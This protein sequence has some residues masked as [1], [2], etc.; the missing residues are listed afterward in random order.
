MADPTHAK[1][2]LTWIAQV[3]AIQGRELSMD[4]TRNTV[5]EWDSLGDL[6]L[7][8]TLEED[9]SI[10][11]SADDIAAITSVAEIVALIEKKN[12]LPPG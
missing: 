1:K 3:L 7:L 4:D 11:V 8:S 6:L 5:A 2:A 9:L 10:V 12:A